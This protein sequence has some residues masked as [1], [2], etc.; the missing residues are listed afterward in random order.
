MINWEARYRELEEQMATMLLQIASKYEELESRAVVAE[1]L[2]IK[3]F[4]VKIDKSTISAVGHASGE[5]IEYAFAIYG[6][7]K[8]KQVSTYSKLNSY[9]FSVKVNGNYRV[10]IHVR[11]ANNPKNVVVKKSAELK[12]AGVKIAK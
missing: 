11:E 1:T 7:N 5:D 10:W 3:E 8:L 12:I 9:N 4:D 2:V 6:P